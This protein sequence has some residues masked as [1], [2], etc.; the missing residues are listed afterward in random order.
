MRLNRKKSANG[1]NGND[2][3]SGMKTNKTLGIIGAGNVGLTLAI[4]AE[5]CGRY[6]VTVG[7]R[8]KTAAIAGLAEFGSDCTVIEPA[9]AAQCDIV[10]LTVPDAAIR[11][12]C[13]SL[14]GRFKATAVVA[15]CSGALSSDE[16]ESASGVAIASMH[17]LQTFPGV[18]E[19]LSRITGTYCYY[20]GDAAAEVVIHEFAENLAM[21][22]VVIRKSAKTLY[23]ASAVMACNYL[24]TLMDASLQLAEAAGIER[25]TMWQ[26][27]DPLVTATLENIHSNGP[28]EALT[29]PIVRGD[30][31]TVSRHI[32]ALQSE[33]KL[34]GL[35]K[36]LGQQT[37]DLARRSGRISDDKLQAVVAAFAD[38]CEK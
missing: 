21:R 13:E 4:L 18:A 28:A 9:D 14:A 27:L 1:L 7:A 6:A 16:L 35:Y 30:A 10:L 24:S 37:V 20:E 29:G 12:V 17:P 26:S 5:R 3:L 38:D 22:P 15:H 19:S 31:E 25:D 11:T 2:T 34:R 8:N 33:E 32:D 23:H 36:V